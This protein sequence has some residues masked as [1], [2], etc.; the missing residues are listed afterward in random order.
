MLPV[1]IFA[2]KVSRDFQ[3]SELDDELFSNINEKSFKVDVETKKTLE[4]SGS[5]HVKYFGV[6]SGVQNF[7]MMC[8]VLG[9]R[10]G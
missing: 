5:Q 9:G 2:S 10:S 4:F 3:N 6:F 1:V 8:H 7:T